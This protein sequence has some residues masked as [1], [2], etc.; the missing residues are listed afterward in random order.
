MIRVKLAPKS[1]VSL[2]L[3]IFAQ[4]RIHDAAT[5]KVSLMAKCI[6]PDTLQHFARTQPHSLAVHY[7]QVTRGDQ[8]L[9]LHKHRKGRLARSEADPTLTGY[10]PNPTKWEST[11]NG[12]RPSLI[13]EMVLDACLKLPGIFPQCIVGEQMTCE[14]ARG[15][16]GWDRRR[17]FS[18]PTQGR[19]QVVKRAGRQAV[20][21]RLL[22]RRNDD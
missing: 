5:I 10:C 14:T 3:H 6:V 22:C 20:Q 11:K 13:P 9:R 12:A 19:V 4:Q 1:F 21:T 8:R 7:C 17:R 2:A 18:R 15:V 16:D